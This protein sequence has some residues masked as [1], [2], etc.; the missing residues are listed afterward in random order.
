MLNVENTVAVC[1]D[2]QV[3]LA[4]VMNR[5]EDL[6]KN[7]R[8]FLSGL[9]VLGVPIIVTEQ[10]PR[11][12]GPTIPD[13][14]EILP[15]VSP[16]IKMSFSCCGESAFMSALDQTERKYVLLVGIET[17]VCVYQTAIELIDRGY[18]VEVVS[19]CIGS[20]TAENK[21]IGMDKMKSYGIE[22]TSAETVLFE[23]LKT[24]ESP[25]FREIAKIVK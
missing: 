6:F 25:K 9:R 8:M 13:V 18:A 24:A 19:D 4:Q 1:I 2:M 15:G 10:N 11:G 7:M 3:K 17:H 16:I 5:K 22:L 23:L 20:R 12:L 21:T 14:S